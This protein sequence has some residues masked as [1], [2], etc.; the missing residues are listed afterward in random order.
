MKNI[1]IL[2]LFI[3]LVSCNN[4]DDQPNS[5]VNLLINGDIEDITNDWFFLSS[6]GSGASNNCFFG[7][8]NEFSFS[9]E[10]ALKIQ[11]DSVINDEIFYYYV[12]SIDPS[13]ISTGS[14][15]ILSAQVKT[16]NLIGEGLSIAL[17][18]DDDQGN[19]VFFET[20]QGSQLIIGTQDFTKYSV[21]LED[22]PGGASIILA[23][24]VYLPET[25]G[26][27]YLDDI[28]LSVE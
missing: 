19:R 11:C 16:E 24:L 1:L 13:G 20:T 17:R 8:T 23:F 14:R 10:N 28:S 22:Y 12:Q 6:M 2:S 27:V 21:S 4:G 5:S 15:I 9:P 3:L 18:G 26:T 25:T 7:P